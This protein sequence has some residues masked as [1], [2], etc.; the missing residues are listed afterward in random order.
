MQRLGLLSQEGWVRYSAVGASADRLDGDA[1]ADAP[2][3]Q[4]AAIRRV[5]G[6]D[7]GRPCT[8]TAEF[9]PLVED[10]PTGRTGRSEQGII[11]LIHIHDKSRGPGPR[12]LLAGAILH[13][14]GEGLAYGLEALLL[15][16][17]T[18]LMLKGWEI[19]EL[20]VDVM[21]APP[22]DAEHIAAIESMFH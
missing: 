8:L 22:G 9:H 13:R 19:A 10:G 15:V 2:V 5:Q 3:L 6:C 17:Q 21:R 4:P 16:K 14:L 12:I 20:L 7:Q 18:Q 1:L 11:M